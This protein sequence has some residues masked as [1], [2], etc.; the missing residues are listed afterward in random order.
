MTAEQLLAAELVDRYDLHP[1]VDVQELA[2]QFADFEV[3][4]WP[5][6]CDG[7]AVLSSERPMIFV[8]ATQ[9]WRR[10]R[11]TIA[12]ELGHVV[13]GWHVDTV[14]C[15][16]GPESNRQPHGPFG[17]NQ[18]AEANRFASHLLVPDRFLDRFADRYVDPSLALAE[19]EQAEVSAAAGVLALNRVLLPGYVFFVPGLDRPVTSHGTRLDA[20]ASKKDLRRN[21]LAWGRT[22]HQGK[23]VEWFQL[24]EGV[25]VIAEPNVPQQVTTGLLW[26]ALAVA[27]FTGDHQKAAQR[28]NGVVGHALSVARDASAENRLGTLRHR[29]ATHPDFAVL[30][31]IPEFEQY[32][33]NKAATPAK[34]RRK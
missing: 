30:L 14:R 9:A 19:I 23:E 24:A 3:C 32:L 12:H 1:P 7:I 34:G 15:D 26:Q 16:T 17:V 28:I 29:V 33:Q 6:D 4:D 21:A 5:Y 18:E 10:Q 11:F 25:E 20:V 27:N 31:A 22:L 8:G 2:E 13:I